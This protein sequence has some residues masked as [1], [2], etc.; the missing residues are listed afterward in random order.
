MIMQQIAGEER[1]SNATYCTMNCMAITLVDRFLAWTQNALSADK[2]S[3]MIR[4]CALNA[5]SH[6]SLESESTIN[7]DMIRTSVPRG[8]LKGVVSNK[9]IV[10]AL[11]D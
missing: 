3:R 8:L 6:H 1:T 11:Q 4:W 10:S 9:R 5:V 7:A 2:T